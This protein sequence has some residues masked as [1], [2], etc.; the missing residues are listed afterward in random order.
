[1]IKCYLEFFSPHP[2]KLK[3]LFQYKYPFEIKK[4]L[5]IC[6]M[7]HRIKSDINKKM[8]KTLSICSELFNLAKENKNDNK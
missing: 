7:K 1:M 3:Y 4:L 6:W 8:I 2:E 5:G